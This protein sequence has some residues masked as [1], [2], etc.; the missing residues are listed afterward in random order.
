MCMHYWQAE[1]CTRGVSDVFY[2]NPRL[3]L[4]RAK[5][6]A[7]SGDGDLNCEALLTDGGP[8]IIRDWQA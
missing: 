1:M 5:V 3:N 6:Y 8:Q 4:S 7:V 2:G